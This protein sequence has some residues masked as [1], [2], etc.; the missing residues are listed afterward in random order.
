MPILAGVFGQW[1]GVSLGESS[2]DV[3]GVSGWTLGWCGGEFGLVCRGG[4][5]AHEIRRGETFPL[6]G[7]TNFAS[8][9][10]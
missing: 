2:T 4:S 6:L 1:L 9:Y 5:G 8:E 10:Q 3:V 7:N